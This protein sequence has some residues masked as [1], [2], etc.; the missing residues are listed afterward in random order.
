VNQDKQSINSHIEEYLD[1][2]CGLNH[3]PGFAVLLQGQWGSGKT[4]FINKYRKIIKGR[5]QKC[6]YVSLYGMTSFADIE[7]AFFQQLHPILSSKGMAITGKILKGIIKGT[8]KIDLDS[9]KNEDG[10]I[11]IQIPD[12]NIPEYLKNTDK[13]ILIFDDLERC[14]IDLSNVLGYINYFVEH[15]DLKVIIIANE[16]ELE[17]DNSYKSIKEKLIG[18]TFG[19]FPDFD[20]ALEDFITIVNQED[21]KIFLSNHTKEIQSLYERAEYENLRNLK[22]IILDFERI[23]NALP[24]KARNK[25]ELLEHLLNMLMAFSIEIKRGSIL[26][27]DIACLQMKYLT[28]G[29]YKMSDSTTDENGEKL[30]QIKTIFDRYPF[31]NIYDPFPS[32]IWWQDFFEKGIVDA[33]KLAQEILSSKYFEDENT[34]DWAKL[35]RFIN[36]GDDDF[37]LVLK[38][39][40]SAWNNFD[41]NEI[42]VVKHV[43]GI[44][45]VLSHHGLYSKSKN[46][47]LEHSKLYVD[48]LKNN[49]QLSR[50]PTSIYDRVDGYHGFGFQGEDFDEFKELSSYVSNV[51]DLAREENMPA[52]GIDLLNI[53]EGDIHKFLEMIYWNQYHGNDRSIVKY[54]DVPILKYIKPYDFTKKLFSLNDECVSFVLNGLNERYSKN[55]GFSLKLLEEL[56][57]IIAVKALIEDEI[58][59]RQGK[60]SGFKLKTWNKKYIDEAIKILESTQV[61]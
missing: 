36:L 51:Q 60:L 38:K 1:Y 35:W 2:Y 52:T 23:F 37:N 39:V 44:L 3:A 58:S 40:E 50:D 56:Q 33:A 6:I 59:N 47:I 12:I 17:K 11:N 19:V 61:P 25:T 21:V 15:Q 8:I 53:M 41:Y 7:D 32:S 14:K 27:K 18:K 49:N 9:N 28:K 31:L 10:R 42:G 29:R 4:W 30:K 45:L 43:Y 22:Q 46:D 5:N 16:S 48:R 24:K 20:G 57:W 34:P 13:S 26:S 54:H 55:N